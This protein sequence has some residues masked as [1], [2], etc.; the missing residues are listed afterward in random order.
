MVGEGQIETSESA[1]T[2]KQGVIKKQ[3]FFPGAM[4]GVSTSLKSLDDA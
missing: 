3:H 1:L 4:A 2:L